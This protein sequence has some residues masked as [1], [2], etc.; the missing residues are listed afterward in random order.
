MHTL[1]LE[2][3]NE[4]ACMIKHSVAHG[5]GKYMIGNE[6]QGVSSTA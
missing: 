5:Y 3:R 4:Y 6:Q 1:N 2:E